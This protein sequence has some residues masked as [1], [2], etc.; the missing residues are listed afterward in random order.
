M[1]QKTPADLSSLSRS[2]AGGGG[3]LDRLSQRFCDDYPEE[4]SHL[5]EAIE[6]H[7]GAAVAGAAHGLRGMLA[8]FGLEGARR[9]LARMEEMGEDSA[10]DGAT[11]LYGELAREMECVREYLLAEG[12]ADREG[13]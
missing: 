12:P 6:A 8:I 10:L 4:M 7:D 3:L 5:R 2:I 13:E 9:T 1:D 11:S